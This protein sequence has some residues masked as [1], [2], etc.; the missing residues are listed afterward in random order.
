MNIHTKEN[1]SLIDTFL[2]EHMP[3]L[4]L[5]PV[6]GTFIGWIDCRALGL[7][8]AALQ[9]F[10]ESAGIYAD[11]G[12]EY[13]PEGSGFYRWNLAAPKQKIQRALNALR[14]RHFQKGVG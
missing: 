10:F 3:K 6:E 11:P 1:A 14:K 7:T 13:G 12:I 4:K 2:K 5:C 9:E 8:D